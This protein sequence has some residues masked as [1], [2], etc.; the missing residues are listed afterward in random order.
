MIYIAYKYTYCPDKAK[1]RDNLKTISET[2]ENHGHETFIL[3]RDK[4][5]WGKMHGNKLQSAV[6]M[7]YKMIL[8]KHVLFFIDHEHPSPGLYLEFKYARFLA[9]PI[10]LVVHKSVAAPQIRQAAD[11]VI[12]FDHHDHLT[13]LQAQLPS[14]LVKAYQTA[15]R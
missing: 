2:L 3:F 11:H 15:Q 1:L 9:K 13:E 8:A 4:R 10:S 7:L 12:E 5:D 14:S 6:F